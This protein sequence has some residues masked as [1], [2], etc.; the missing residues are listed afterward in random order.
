LAVATG[1]GYWMILGVCVSLGKSGL[2]PAW[3]AAWIPN[4]AFGALAVST[5]LLGEEKA[6]N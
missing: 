3:P 1:V 4:F 2:M 6:P 5:F